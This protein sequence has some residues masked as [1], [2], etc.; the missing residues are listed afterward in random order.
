MVVE[1]GVAVNVAARRRRR[2]WALEPTL[3]TMRKFSLLAR[4]RAKIA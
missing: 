4:F 2:A 3:R 1:G